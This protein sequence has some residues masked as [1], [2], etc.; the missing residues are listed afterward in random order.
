MRFD[1]LAETADDFLP[2]GQ[3]VV[4]AGGRAEARAVSRHRSDDLVGRGGVGLVFQSDLRGE[5]RDQGMQSFQVPGHPPA[6]RLVA[7]QAAKLKLNRHRAP[8]FGSGNAFQQLVIHQRVAG[9]SI[10]P[11]QEGAVGAEPQEDVFRFDVEHAESVVLE[12]GDGQAGDAGQEAVAA[13]ALQLEGGGRLDRVLAVNPAVKEDV[14]PAGINFQPGMPRLLR[15]D[16][17]LLPSGLPELEAAR[18]T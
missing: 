2:G 6:R 5:Q 17:L 9:L 11:Q 10:G 13:R 7:V 1:L 15:G 16:F 4:V 3:P 12:L 14:L 18:G 8:G